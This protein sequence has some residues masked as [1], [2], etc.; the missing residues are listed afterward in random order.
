MG[1]YNFLIGA[2]G[3]TLEPNDTL[4]PALLA[5]P[6]YSALYDKS[7]I[8]ANKQIVIGHGETITA[9]ADGETE[10]T[11]TAKYNGDTYT[12]T[13]NVTVKSLEYDVAS[14]R[15]AADIVLARITDSIEVGEDY[16]V[17]AYVLSEIT[18][19]HPGSYLYSDDNLVRYTSDN[20]SVCRVKNGVLHGVSIGTATI[21]AADITGAVRKSFTVSVVEET[22]LEY[23]NNEVMTVNTE[24]YDWTDAEMTTVAIKEI[25]AAASASGMKKVIF[26]EQIY[27][28]SPAYGTIQ[29][30]T[31]MIVDFSGSVVQIQPNDLAGDGGYNMI[32]FY[33]TEY[34]SI[35]NARIYGERFLI[36]EGAG[37]GLCQS[38]QIAGKCVKSGLKNC[39]ISRSP[40]FNTGFSN[41]NRKLTGFKL[42]AVEAGGI[43]D[44]GNNIDAAY[45]FRHNSF[46][47]ISSIGSRF[48][49]GNM[50]GYQGY[51]YLGA[52]CYDI[53]F[54]D[55]AKA[56]ISCLKNCI[57]YYMY[58]KP[59]NA[60][61]ARIT[62]HSPSAPTASDPDYASIAH[63]Y[64][65]DKPDRCY[66]KNCT[67]EDSYSLAC[68]TNGG[69]NMLFDGCTFKNNGYRD[70]ASHLD[71]ED[72]RNHNKGHI[73]RNCTFEGGGHAI[74]VLGSD[75]IVIRNNTFKDTDLRVQS[76]AQNSRV[77]LNQFIGKGATITTKTDM[78]FSQNYAAEG[79]TFTV[80]NVDGVNF[81]VR[82]ECNES[83][84]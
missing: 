6:L 12:D 68:N 61:Y 81:A 2:D 82:Q 56:F 77:W 84:E 50:Q 13:A 34:S 76:E 65:L 60:A 30:P 47:S 79:A 49:F 80:T 16:S 33:D 24:D 83:A 64:S 26:P 73:V 35:E 74:L 59:D 78:V 75:G 45:T 10:I 54:Y 36:A 38:V 25:L 41:A 23:A 69:E 27:E 62:F 29:I 52:R 63:I 44:N 37:K 48:G 51:A 5:K 58:D 46:M 14:A 67:F 57:Q 70:P 8:S 55:S 18:A 31:R 1:A 7:V 71:W 20:P 11:V 53:F 32:Q 72:G 9:V 22:T 43:D 42:A 66:F 28:I 3:Y 40:G 39:T 15:T 19:D 21:T 17:Q 4:A